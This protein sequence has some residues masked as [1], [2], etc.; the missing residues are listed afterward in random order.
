MPQ[1]ARK[2]RLAYRALCLLL[3]TCSLALGA[4]SAC[5]SRGEEGGP[6]TPSTGASK[7]SHVTSETP[8]EGRTFTV[9]VSLGAAE[10]LD[11]ALQTAMEAKAQADNLALEVQDAKQDRNRQ[12]QQVEAFIARHVDAIVLCPTDTEAAG[13]AVQAANA[14]RVPVFTVAMQA[15]ERIPGSVQSH[16]APDDTQSG[17]LA[18]HKMAELLHEKGTVLIFG[19]TGLYKERAQAFREEIAHHPGLKLL[20][21]IPEQG[22]RTTLETQAVSF[23]NQ[24]AAALQNH[25][26]LNRSGPPIN[27]IF[28]LDDAAALAA[29]AACDKARRADIVIVGCDGGPEARAAIKRG[30]NLKADVVAS[31]DKVGA[32]AIE[33]V[34][35]F[36]QRKTVSAHVNVE[37]GIL[38]MTHNDP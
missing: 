4:L 15:A 9:G 34:L 11:R 13:S 1:T 26:A 16:I 20:P 10:D 2:G 7:P 12:K 19:A 37:I 8:T 27:G 21:D 28:A 36:L 29:L 25:A 33:T 5:S 24:I 38:D 35:A 17:R 6:T 14:A 18:A 22:S 3:P 32:H 30:A 23:Q 31:P